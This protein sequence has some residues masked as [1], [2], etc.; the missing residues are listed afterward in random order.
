MQNYLSKRRNCEAG[1]SI[2][3]DALFRHVR[4][5][6]EIIGHRSVQN[7]DSLQKTA[8]YISKELQNY[9]YNVELQ[10]YYVPDIRVNLMHAQ[11]QQFKEAYNVIAT[12]RGQKAP[13]EVIV[14]GAHYD[15]WDSPGADDNAS[16]IAGML[17]IARYL[18]D[19]TTQRTVQFVGFTNEEPPFFHTDLMGSRVYAKA[20]KNLKA[21]IKL[22]IV[23]EMI[24][25][26]SDMPL[27]QQIPR[28]L[29]DEYPDRGNFI[30][31]IGDNIAMPLLLDLARRYNN[32]SKVP[33][34]TNNGFETIIQE[35]DGFNFSDHWSFW[36]EGY[37]A[38][39]ITD[40]AF[41]RNPHYHTETDTYGTLNYEK[42]AEVVAGLGQALCD[43]C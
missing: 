15:S 33:M 3:I 32:T 23:L 20:A 17:E 2:L 12:K 38:V 29:Q 19:I 18:A 39:M 42:M 5:L 16:G 37:P 7:Y 8:Q 36:Q 34:M 28:L 14:V 25:Y 40:T 10:K 35:L 21:D 6:S 1:I 13:E 26:F 11:P 41:L 9:G 30:M 43:F 27:S 4:E 24:G 31:A 22:A